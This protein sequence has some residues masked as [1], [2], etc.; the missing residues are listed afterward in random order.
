M[1]HKSS[2]AKRPV[3]FAI[4]DEMKQWSAMLGQELSTW[5]DIVTRPM[6]GMIAYYRGKTIFAG[7]PNTR[8]LSHPTSIIFRFDPLPAALIKR[9]KSQTGLHPEEAFSKGHCLSLQLEST[10][11]LND[12]LWWLSHAYEAAVPRKIRRGKLGEKRPRRTR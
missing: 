2:N 3:L 7:L 4:S 1:K 9:A 8:A 5:P 6:F 12:A 10:D 11:S